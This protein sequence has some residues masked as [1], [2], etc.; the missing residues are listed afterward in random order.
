[1]LII[2]YIKKFFVSKDFEIISFN[3]LLSFFAVTVAATKI[4]SE[5]VILKVKIEFYEKI[6]MFLLK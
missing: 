1:M 3:F 4:Y 2:F 5:M 6:I